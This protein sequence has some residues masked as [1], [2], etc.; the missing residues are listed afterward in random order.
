MYMFVV[1]LYE[2]FAVL[3]RADARPKARLF[4]VVVILAIIALVVFLD[5]LVQPM[6]AKDL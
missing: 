5:S 6:N 3:W 4:T 2:L 1:W